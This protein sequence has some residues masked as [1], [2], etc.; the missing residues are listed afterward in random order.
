MDFSSDHHWLLTSYGK[1][2]QPGIMRLLMEVHD[3]AYDLSLPINQKAS[4]SNNQSTGDI[5]RRGTFELY[6]GYAISKIYTVGY[7]TRE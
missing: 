6:H 3:I 5:R 2:N 4:R 1:K 7:S